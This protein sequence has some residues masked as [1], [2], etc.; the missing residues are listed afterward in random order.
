[1]LGVK[2]FSFDKIN[3]EKW[4]MVNFKINRLPNLHIVDRYL[5]TCK[6]LGIENDDE[7]LDYFIATRD[8]VDIQSLPPEFSNGYIGWV[9]GAKH[10]TKQFPFN[11]IVSALLKITGPVVL[12]GGKEDAAVGEKIV[13]LAGGKIIFNACGKYSLN[14]SA[15]L[16]RQAKV[17]VTND[18]GLMHIAAA[19]KK[20]V[21][22][23]W[24]NTVPEFG[25]TPYFG[26][27]Y[28]AIGIN[29][30]QFEVNGL[31][32]RPCSK[33]GYSACPKGH[34]KC[35]NMIDEMEVAKAVA[36]LGG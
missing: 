12:L 24:G 23:I 16:V 32:C 27:N 2:S 22:S 20:P 30:R 28:L 35:M 14:Q 18:T 11:K 1:M 13:G 10:A 29:S 31:S 36:A 7:G 15:S 9:I 4:L 3:F 21:I 8:E 5:A 34:F 25:M 17:I 26:K 19:Y 6:T 33:L